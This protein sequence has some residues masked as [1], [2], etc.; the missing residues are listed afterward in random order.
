MT[1]HNSCPICRVPSAT[2]F[3]SINL[4]VNCSTL[5]GS[6]DEARSA[7]KGPIAL[8]FCENCGM[9]FNAAF[10]PGLLEYDGAYDNSLHFSP[11]FQGYCEC[12]IARLQD[13]Y[14]LRNIVVVE[15]G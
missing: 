6:R 12:L 3:L 2:E 8:A 15:V 7:R 14:S 10:D 4:P 5:F 1:L 9:I 11:A 13:T